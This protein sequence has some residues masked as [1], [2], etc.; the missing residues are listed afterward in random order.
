MKI[1]NLLAL[2]LLGFILNSCGSDD[3]SPKEEFVSEVKTYDLKNANIYL[4]YSWND[5]DNR[6]SRDYFIT[7]GVYTN[8]DGSNG[9]SLDD[10]T[11]ATFLIAVEVSSPVGGSLMK[12]DYLLYN[13][14][15]NA[16][17][18]ESISY[19]YA[20]SDPGDFFIIHDQGDNPDGQPIKISGG[21]DDGETIKMSFDGTL[22]V[23]YRIEGSRFIQN[24]AANF[25]FSGKVQD[26]REF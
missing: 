13:N 22:R 12:G 9:W 19:I 26:V 1:K 7:D 10:Y 6:E 24:K 11:N 25:Y 8:G 20:E 15:T 21:F 5:F 4:T 14:W 3:A 2:V 23:N 16:A 18:N 17:D